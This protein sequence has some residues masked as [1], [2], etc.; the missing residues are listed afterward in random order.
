MLQNDTVRIVSSQGAVQGHVTAIGDGSTDKNTSNVWIDF[1][2]SF[3]VKSG[4]PVQVAVDVLGAYRFR[5]SYTK[6]NKLSLC[7]SV[8]QEI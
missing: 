8:Q 2:E 5:P 1:D 6:A 7:N 3:D 4:T